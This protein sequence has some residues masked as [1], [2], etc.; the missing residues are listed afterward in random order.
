M[1]GLADGTEG[2]KARGASGVPCGKIHKNACRA[3]RRSVHFRLG[4]EL[5]RL[6]PNR[7]VEFFDRPTGPCSPST[8]GPT[9]FPITSNHVF[10]TGSQRLRPR[11]SLS[12]R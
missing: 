7:G 9:G 10:F 6:S 3:M 11:L 5:V 8:T 4:V 1:C 2:Q 12:V